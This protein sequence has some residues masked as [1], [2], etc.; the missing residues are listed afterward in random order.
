MASPGKSQ[1][2]GLPGYDPD[3]IQPWLVQVVTAMTIL[4][5]VSVALRLVSR[6]IMGQKLWWDDWMIL[7][8]MV[9]TSGI[10]IAAH[11]LGPFGSGREGL[12]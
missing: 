5:V 1:L 2:P 12:T 4:V 8:S 11:N 9:C 7:F 6:R 10:P 3:N